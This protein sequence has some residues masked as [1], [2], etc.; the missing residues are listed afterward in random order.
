MRALILIAPLCVALS[1]ISFSPRSGKSGSEPA[2][3]A[4]G[5]G[6]GQTEK[7]AIDSARDNAIDHLLAQQDPPFIY[8][9][10][11]EFIRD[12]A[13]ETATPVVRKIDP[14]ADQRYKATLTMDLTSDYRELVEKDRSVRAA[15]RHSAILP[16][17]VAVVIL[18]GAGGVYYRVTRAKAASPR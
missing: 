7:E 10:A 12:H 1:W 11:E 14:I 15:G 4:D 17:F 5:V 3:K 6:Y 2:I 18:L 9:R 16:A 8:S 13:K